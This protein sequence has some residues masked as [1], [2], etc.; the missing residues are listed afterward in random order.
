ME[1]RVAHYVVQLIL[2]NNTLP[3]NT[4]RVAFYNVGIRFE[5]EKVEGHINDFF[6]L[7][8]H[9]AFGNPKSGFGNRYSEI[10]D[11][12]PVKLTDRYLYQIVKP[13]HHLTAMNK[14]KGFIL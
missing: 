13:K 1:R 10:V 6:R 3:I 9:L 7:L 14:F 12:D 5:R 11:F 8:H 2:G 4:K